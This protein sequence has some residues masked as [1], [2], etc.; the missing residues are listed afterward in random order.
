MYVTSE[1]TSSL[2]AVTMHEAAPIEGRA[3]VL[4]LFREDGGKTRNSFFPW[5]G[6]VSQILRCSSAREKSLVPR[7]CCR[8]PYKLFFLH[9]YVLYVCSMYSRHRPIYVL[10]RSVFLALGQLLFVHSSQK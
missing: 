2:W 10:R 8:N 6:D 9:T 3:G 5:R 1:L 7:D 4:F